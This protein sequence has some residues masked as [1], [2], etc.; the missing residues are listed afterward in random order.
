MRRRVHDA[1]DGLDPTVVSPAAK[2]DEREVG[3]AWSSPE[4]FETDTRDP[5]V[6]DNMPRIAVFK[7]TVDQPQIVA[8]IGEV[9]AA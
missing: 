9:Q 4:P 8:A 3:L 2:L 7:V 1:L 5:G 6:M